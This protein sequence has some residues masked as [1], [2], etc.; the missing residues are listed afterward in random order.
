MKFLLT[1]SILLISSWNAF[2][3]TESK[4]FHYLDKKQWDEA[5]SA[6]SKSGDKLLVKIAKARKFILAKP[7]ENNFEEITSFISQNP[8]WPQICSIKEAAEGAI[9]SSTDK[10]KIVEYFGAHPAETD[11]GAK[12]YAIAAAKVV[13]DQSKLKRIVREGWIYGDFTKAEADAFLKQN[14]KLLNQADHAKKIDYIIW[15]RDPKKIDG[16]LSLVSAHDREMFKAAIAF[17]T[18][19]HR[20]C[21]DDSKNKTEQSAAS[22]ATATDRHGRCQNHPHDD[23]L[24][25]SVVLYSYLKLYKSDDV[26]ERL[27][28]LIANAPIDHDHGSEWWALKSLFARELMKQKNYQ[29]AYNIVKNH[30]AFKDED[31]AE[32]EFLSGFLALRF[33]HKPRVAHKHF[34]NMLA[35]VKRPISI[36]K[37]SY[38]L[39]RSSRDKK[40]AHKWFREASAFNYTFYGQLAMVEMGD[41][42]IT[43]P[44]RPQVQASHRK[45]YAQ[46]E[47]ARAASI[48][49][50]YGKE[51]LAL[52]YAKEAIADS[53]SPEEAM[54][55]IDSFK[56]L[57]K[58]PFTIGIAKAA[59]YRNIFIAR[60]AFPMPHKITNNFVEPAVAYSIMRQETMF[61]HKAVSNRDARGLMQLIPSTACSTARSLKIKCELRQLLTHP[62]YNIKLGCRELRNRIDKYDGS[63]ILTFAAYNAGPTPTQRWINTYGDPRK[64]KDI[65]K[66][67]D[68]IESIPYHQTRE[69]IQRITEN[70]QIYRALLGKAELRIKRDLGV[71]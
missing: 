45:L 53:S 5:I 51:E 44:P 67:V 15:H 25:H 66:V 2:A 40:E 55:I 18:G 47:L 69:Y 24:H 4:V 48:L 8:D 50:K 52:L 42:A 49:L 27:G 9:N 10:L 12:S 3:S 26:D 62:E 37:A 32:A 16:L 41:K 46:N 19:N 63:Y 39:G 6:A 64:F 65:H 29:L 1:L 61:D 17:R 13:K 20:H 56:G 59:A 11:F 70:L 36:A 28:K 71:F 54:L 22:K 23:E 31:I 34:Q 60:E 35:V 57:G 43:L 33:L 7:E 14:G 68:W 38:W 58:P 30:H 21:Q